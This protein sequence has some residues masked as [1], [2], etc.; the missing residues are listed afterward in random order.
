[1]QKLSVKTVMGVASAI[2]IA[3]FAYRD[4]RKKTKQDDKLEEHDGD[5]ETLKMENAAMK[6]R[7]EVLE[8]K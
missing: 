2:V 6:Q 3:V 4:E 8:N 7:L 1:M 5:I